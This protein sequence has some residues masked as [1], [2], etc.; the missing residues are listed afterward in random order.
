MND[1]LRNYGPLAP[2][3]GEW[4]G[5]RGIDLAPEPDGEERE[6]YYETLIF[7]P[8]GDVSNAEKEC[9]YA[10][11][12]HQVVYRI[13]NDEPFHNQT[14]YWMWSALTG[15]VMQSLTIPRGICLLAGG[16]FSGDWE[17]GKPVTLEVAARAGDGN[18]GIVE[19]PFMGENASTRSF[20]H[21]L[22]VSGDSLEYRETTLLHIYGR[23]FDH[24]D[25]NILTRK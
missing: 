19:S 10:L 18:W 21:T 8:I 6:P 14:G 17:P 3:I 2:L 23:D 1:E 11:R 15:K 16:D 22:T 13:R 25:G 7:E 20:A 24:V 5:N 4:H 12:Y 9:I